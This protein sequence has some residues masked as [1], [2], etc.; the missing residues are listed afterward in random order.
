MRKAFVFSVLVLLML[1][2]FVLLVDTALVR[3]PFFD[4]RQEVQRSR[5]IAARDVAREVAKDFPVTASGAS[6][7]EHRTSNSLSDFET[8]LGQWAS[9][10][11][12]YEN[13][14]WQNISIDDSED[15]LPS[16]YRL[17]GPGID[18]SWNGTNFTASHQSSSIVL[19]IEGV[20][21]INYDWTPALGGIGDIQVGVCVGS[22]NTSGFVSLGTTY[23]GFFNFSSSSNLT[24]R[25]LSDGSLNVDRQYAGGDWN[26]TIGLDGEVPALNILWAAEVVDTLGTANPGW[27]EPTY[28]NGTAS[29]KHYGNNTHNVILADTDNDG[30]Y[31]AAFLD[32]DG[33][34][35]FSELNDV[36]LARSGS[37]V[38]LGSKAFYITFE[39]D[40]S[41]AKLHKTP[42]LMTGSGAAPIKV[43]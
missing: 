32:S 38:K 3:R 33:D 41:E 16:F 2:S 12:D 11:L 39:S 17:A 42:A 22:A 19:F 26:Q 15:T 40:G 34:G 36:W 7:R 9:F 27:T 20:D 10:I 1:T 24:V 21:P 37:T 13:R 23:E 25:F 14:S 8:R 31:D 30:S 28:P 4:V 43:S 18:Y 5:D 35:D 6:I 29:T